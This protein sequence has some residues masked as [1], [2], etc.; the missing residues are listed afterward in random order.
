MLVSATVEILHVV[1]KMLVE[2]FKDVNFGHEKFVDFISYWKTLA[3]PNGLPY[4][5]DFNP[6]DV[7]HLLQDITIYEMLEDDTLRCRL[8]GTGLVEGF[9]W[10]YTDHDYLSLW[11][12]EDKPKL[13]Y[14]FK[15]MLEAKMGI[16]TYLV[17]I[18]ASGFEVSGPAM[19]LPALDGNGKA[20]R[21]IALT[22][23]DTPQNSRDPREDKV[24]QVKATRISFID[25]N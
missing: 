17:A 4:Q 7:R 15:K 12:E 8:M 19:C 5:S 23:E 2:K 10:D 3:K 20:T 16:W 14:H 25:F 18:A 24:V 9:G 21:I 13:L 6:A 22:N 1:W 11:A